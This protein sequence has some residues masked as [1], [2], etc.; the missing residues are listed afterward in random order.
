MITKIGQ[1]TLPV[2]MSL[3]FCD[4]QMVGSE[5]AINNMDQSCLG[6]KVQAGAMVCSELSEIFFTHFGPVCKK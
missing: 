1:K 5:I 3:D 2:R 4:I 6:S